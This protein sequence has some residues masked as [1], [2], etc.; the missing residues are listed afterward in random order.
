M[1]IIFNEKWCIFCIRVM[2]DF[3]LKLVYNKQEFVTS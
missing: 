3:W 2:V 1:R